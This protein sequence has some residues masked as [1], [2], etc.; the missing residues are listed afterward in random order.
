VKGEGTGLNEPSVLAVEKGD[1]GGSKTPAIRKKAKMMVGR[2]T[3]GFSQRWQ[4][5]AS[6]LA[7][8]DWPLD[9]FV[10][11]QTFVIQ[12]LL[13]FL[14]KSVT[15]TRRWMKYGEKSTQAEQ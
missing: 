8:L 10:T 7:Y 4:S 11:H 15:W 1:M 5:W 2:E 6:L 13:F 14:V 3:Y 12:G 9:Y